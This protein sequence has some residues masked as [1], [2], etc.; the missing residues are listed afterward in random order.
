MG[1]DLNLKKSWHPQLLRNQERVWQ[2]EKKALEERKRIDQWKKE[3]EEERQLLE[4]R[5]IQEAAGGKTVLDRV[6][7]LYNGPSQGMDR[8]T[9]ENEAYLLGKRRIDSLLK[10]SDNEKL[11]K[12]SGQEGFLKAQTANTLRDTAAKV[13]DDPLLAIKKQEQMAYESYMK[14]PAKRRLIQ[15]ITAVT[16]I[17]AAETVT[18]IPTAVPD[19][20]PTAEAEDIDHD[21]APREET[22]TIKTVLHTALTVTDPAHQSD[23]A[24]T[25]LRHAETT[26]ASAAS[27]EIEKSGRIDVDEATEVTEVIEEETETEMTAA[28][29]TP[30]PA[31]LHHPAGPPPLHPAIV[32]PLPLPLVGLKTPNYHSRPSP[33]P[34]RHEKALSKSAED[35]EAERARKLAEMQSNA[36]ELDA[37]RAKRLAALAEREKAEAEREEA[38]RRRN[39]KMGGRAEFIGAANRKAAE[40]DLGER[41]SRGRQG[42]VGRDTE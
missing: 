25:R 42:L 12:D 36:T 23:H 35:E 38:A 16:A 32:T 22:A 13:R 7:F 3:R 18:V 19:A 6:D 21:P 34:R 1:G 8:T 39:G 29:P 4:L 37:D 41:V 40:L 11:K 15:K 5:Q 20:V 30:A 9:E 33:P 14:D 2:E 10:G 17:T 26:G 27:A 28:A 24:G 31:A